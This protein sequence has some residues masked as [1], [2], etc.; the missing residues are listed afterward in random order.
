MSAGAGNGRGEAAAPSFHGRVLEQLKHALEASE[1]PPEATLHQAL[2]LLAQY[3][4]V[5]VANTVSKELERKVHGGPFK[6]MEY[7]DRVTEGCF[8]PKLLGC[9][10]AEL[11]PHIK[12]AIRRG[13]D[14]VVNIGS[15]EGYYAVGMALR[16][17]E[18]EIRAY[19]TDP[20]SQAACRKLA[21]LNGVADQ[22]KI[23]GEFRGQ[24]FD[25]LAAE[26]GRSLV[27]CDIEGAERDLIDPAAYPGLKRL[28]LFVELHDVLDPKISRRVTERFAE[29]HEVMIVPHAISKVELPPLFQGLDNL[30]RL[31]GVWEWRSGPTPWVVM[32]ARDTADAG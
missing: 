2:R 8:A 17:P 22:V 28:D 6:G 15:A 31:L 1:A 20:K 4:S 12:G 26:G 3:R 25:A 29:S 19:D 32:L 11:H 14:R 16:L 13:Y 21:E 7:L 9:Y 23:A 27:L 30:D 18:A 24:D 5:L 10:E